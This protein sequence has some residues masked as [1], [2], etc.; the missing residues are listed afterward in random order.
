MDKGVVEGG[1]DVR[2]TEHQLTLSHLAQYNNVSLQNNHCSE[3]CC[4][5]GGAEII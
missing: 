2:N 3:Q 1:E 4:G 5:A